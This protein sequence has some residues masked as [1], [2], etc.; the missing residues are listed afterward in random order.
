MN[1][2]SLTL[3]CKNYGDLRFQKTPVDCN[4]PDSVTALRDRPSSSLE[5]DSQIGNWMI[6][7]LK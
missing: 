6:W 3:F 1:K 2:T 4:I 5:L 7:L